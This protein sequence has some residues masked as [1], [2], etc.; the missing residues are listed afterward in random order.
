MVKQILSPL[1]TPDPQEQL[2]KTFLRDE[3][4]VEIE[5]LKKRI[6]QLELRLDD[7]FG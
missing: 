4:T 2:F 3:V 7:P 1:G 6:K 5:L